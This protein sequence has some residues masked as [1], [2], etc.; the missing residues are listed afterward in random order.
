M[1]A[2]YLLPVTSGVPNESWSTTRRIELIRVFRET[3]TSMPYDLPGM[4]PNRFAWPPDLPMTM[5]CEPLTPLALLSCLTSV[6]AGAMPRDSALVRR[7][8]SFGDGGCVNPPGVD[9]AEYGNGCGLP[10][11]LSLLPTAL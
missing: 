8:V 5:F 6:P 3:V 2:G 1:P 10:P 7:T 4:F 9:C 11:T